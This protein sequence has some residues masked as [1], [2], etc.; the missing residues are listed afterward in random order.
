ML[1]NKDVNKTLI[2]A[3]IHEFNTKLFHVVIYFFTTH[4]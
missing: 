4:N 1:D 3:H 2:N